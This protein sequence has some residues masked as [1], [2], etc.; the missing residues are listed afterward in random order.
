MK[1][2]IV[3]FSVFVVFA[4]I[5]LS[6]IF[7]PQ[8]AIEFNWN[9]NNTIKV[10]PIVYDLKLIPD[11][12]PHSSIQVISDENFTTYGF[13]GNGT[14][15]E[16]Y[17]IENIE[18]ITDDSVGILI[19]N[20][21]K[22]FIIKNCFISALDIGIGINK[23]SK[24]TA[25]IEN[26]TCAN[27]NYYGIYLTN[28]NGIRVENNLCYGNHYGI[29]INNALQLEIISNFCHS[30]TAGVYVLYTAHTI[31]QYNLLAYN[32]NGMFLSAYEKSNITENIFRRNTYTGIRMDYSKHS[33][34]QSNL[35][36]DGVFGIIIERSQN[37]S[38]SQNECTNSNIDGIFSRET[39]DSIITENKCSQHNNSGI[40]IDRCSNITVSSNICWENKD[41]GIWVYY[42]DFTNLLPPIIDNNIC[43]NNKLGMRI[44][45]TYHATIVNNT[46]ESNGH[47]ILL[48]DAKYNEIVGNILLRNTR[49]GVK[50][51]SLLSSG[52]E[53]YSN[54]FVCNNLNGTE[55]GTSQA[56][57]ES[58]SDWYDEDTNTGN[59]WT[60]YQGEGEYQIDGERE[61]TDPY[62]MSYKCDCFET[63][64]TSG[65]SYL[66]A[67]ILLL[68]FLGVSEVL[69]KSNN[70][71]LRLI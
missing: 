58:F 21:T 1:K 5:G 45:E 55:D 19:Y 67:F 57:D 47:G 13:S 27:H 29:L 42:G 7:V 25:V 40:R 31:M 63:D 60:D 56:Y 71:T 15:S 20:T 22:H 2:P 50:I 23:I 69:K 30:N 32:Y 6:F 24:D 62:P 11:L 52:N 4:L 43:K 3:K 28:S 26:N 66:S 9:Q 34:I 38:I 53:I 37:I 51:D 35:C 48:T 18:V 8:K 49:Y 70:R 33:Y 68:T 59:Y 10:G 17:R 36:T 61:R 12:T 65:Q 64:K 46:C 54:Y 41:S 44:W 39:D 16:P 14:V